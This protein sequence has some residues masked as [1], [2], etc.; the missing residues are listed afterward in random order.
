[1]AR[2]NLVDLDPVLTERLRASLTGSP[3]LFLPTPEPLP[4]DEA[5]LCVVPAARVVSL[6]D[7]GVPLIACGPA[8]LLRACFV[9]GC[10]DYLRDPWSPEELAVRARALLSRLASRS[11]LLWG[12]AELQGNELRS[13]RG[14]VALTHHEAVILR[15]L[16]G[17]RGRPVPRAALSYSLEGREGRAASRAIDMHVSALRRKA[18]EALPDVRCP[19]VCV[20]GMGYMVAQEVEL[21]DN[22]RR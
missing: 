1:M 4:P 15:M 11:R 5:D 9:A 16:L 10:A 6:P 12:D 20:K 19:I 17:N 22:A 7:T 18:R 13:A 14:V 8:A 2:I 21:L 3:F